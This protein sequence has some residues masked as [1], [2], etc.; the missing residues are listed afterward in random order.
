MLLVLSP[1]KTL[2]YET[3]I[4][5]PHTQ[6]SMLAESEKL[7]KEL[8]KFDEKKLGKLMDISPKLS[9][10]NVQRYRDFKTPFSTKNA[11][12]A[13]LAFKGDVYDGIEVEKYSKNDFEFAQDHVRILSGLYG[14]LRPLDL[15]QPYRL[16]MGTT[17]K[18]AKGK[19]LYAFWGDSI[20]Q[21]I[22]KE[23][24]AHKTKIL[25]NLASEEYFKA[26]RPTLFEGS[27]LNIAFKERQKGGLK[28]IGLFAKKARGHMANWVIRNRIDDVAALRQFSHE[29]YRFE[30][31]L[32]SEEYWVFAR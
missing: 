19:D 23:L 32:S 17:L 25:L 2:D 26:V 11:R 8:R 28:I 5:A 6:P 14:L 4:D 3:P 24:Q 16:E 7:I 15:M 22:N 9:A 18:N 20:T 1:S 10:L 30:K 29:G 13:I 31:A 12:Q 21:A 27:L